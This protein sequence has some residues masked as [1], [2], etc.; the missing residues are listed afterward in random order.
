MNLRK[1]LIGAFYFYLPKL[2]NIPPPKKKRGH[3]PPP[4]PIIV[5]DTPSLLKVKYALAI[6]KTIILI[7]MTQFHA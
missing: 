7:Q 2:L 1:A 4:Y 6:Y 5:Y 3:T